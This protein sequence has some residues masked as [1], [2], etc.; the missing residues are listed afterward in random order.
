MA[1]PERHSDA[2]FEA[3][4]ALRK[5]IKDQGLHMAIERM[6]VNDRGLAR[7]R[8]ARALEF[9]ANMGRLEP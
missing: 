2:E 3:I 5:Q 9:H 8:I 1:Q 7:R 4:L 6:S